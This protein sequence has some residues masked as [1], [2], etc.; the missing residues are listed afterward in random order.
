[1]TPVVV[2]D[3]GVFLVIATDKREGDLSYEQVKS[4]IAKE[5]ARDVW[6]KEAAKRDALDALAKA[7]AG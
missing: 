3:R 5:L 6:G 2:T 4:E 1:M 7:Q